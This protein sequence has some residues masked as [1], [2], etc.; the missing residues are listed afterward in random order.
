M[1]GKTHIIHRVNLEID[2]PEMRLANKVKDDAL[3]LLYNE[4]LPK[5]EKYMDSLIPEDEYI[6]LERLNIDIGQLSEAHFDE[7]FTKSVVRRF[8]EKAEKIVALDRERGDQ[9]EAEK[10][11]KFTKEESA[12]ECFLFFLE[13]GS[14]PWWSQKSGELLGEKNLSEA[15]KK[16][17]VAFQKRLFSLLGE[18][19]VARQRLL[20]QFSLPFIFQSVLVFV[21]EEPTRRIIQLLQQFEAKRTTDGAGL[22]KQ[23]HAFLTRITLLLLARDEV[24]SGC[25]LDA[26]IDEYSANATLQDIRFSL[27][28]EELKST[29][30][31]FQKKISRKSDFQKTKEEK[32]AVAKKQEKQDVEEDGFFVDNAG[33]VL[34]HPFLSSLFTDFELLAEG[35]FKNR[36]S[37]T[38][39]VHLLHYL[40]T[41]QEFASEHELAMEQFLCGWDTDWPIEREVA[42][43]RE[44]KNECETLLTAAIRHWSALKNTSPNGLREGFLQREGKL[45]L[46][47]FQDRLIVESK[48]HD[49]LL[50]YLPWGYSIFKLSWMKS[51]LYIEWQ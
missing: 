2:V 3:R 28:L 23:Q 41:K 26:I 27:L 1:N 36:E 48:S 32:K 18:N 9:P 46:N 43:S 7:E 50:S 12:C 22:L 20:N 34:L 16:S 44:M 8:H 4:V 15:L 38:I 19:P 30:T 25:Q 5:L 33:L 11:V 24:F 42:L 40:A 17:S 13:T 49:V 45:I 47:D 14:L 51:A 35:Q 21:A 29:V 31:P 39:A 6:R 37:Q 10:V